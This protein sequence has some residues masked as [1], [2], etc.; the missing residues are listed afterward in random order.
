MVMNRYKAG[1]IHFAICAAVAVL[2]YALLHSIFYPAPLLRAV[3]G[4]EIFLIILACDVIIGPLLTTIVYRVGKSSLRFDLTV[5]AL[6]QIA[7]LGYG[8]HTLWTGRPVYL[9]ALGH[10]VDLIQASDIQDKNLEDAKAVLP[11][12]GPRWVGVNPP[13][14]RQERDKVMWQAIA[15]G[16]DYGHLPKYHAPIESMHV[17][18]L[19]RA[20]S[21]ENLK[22]F[23]EGREA[24]I[25]EWFAAQKIDPAKA[26]FQGLKAPRHD[27]AV[28]LDATTGRVLAIAPFAPWK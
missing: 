26:K 19:S 7:A 21:I 13:K 5:I 11:R 9:A 24:Q 23:N 3:G 18:M 1:G 16:G 14:D 27:M 20:E 4:L 22:K 2:L 10:R 15:G 6:L 17:E 8:L 28:V 25:D 12:F